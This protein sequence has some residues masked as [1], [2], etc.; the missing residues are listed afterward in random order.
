M[1]HGDRTPTY[2]PI[3][4][5]DPYKNYSYEPYGS[6][7]LTNKGK[8][9]QYEIGLNL[10][11]RYNEFL[12]EKFDPQSFEGIS[13]RMHR[14]QTSLQCLLAG[15]FPPKDKLIWK[16]DLLW[17]PLGYHSENSVLMSAHVCPDFKDLINKYKNTSYY[18]DILV[19]HSD[20]I[21]Y[22]NKNAGSE[23]TDAYGAYKLYCILK[24]QS[25]LGLELPKWTKSIFPEKLASLAVENYFQYCGTTEAKRIVTGYLLRKI[26]L[27]SKRKIC[28]KLNPPSRKLFLYSGHQLNVAC[29]LET[30]G[31]FKK[32]LPYYGS[33]IIVE[34]H[35]VNQTYGFK[36]YYKRKLEEK[37]ELL[38]IPTCGEFC[39]FSDFINIYSDMIPTQEY[40]NLPKY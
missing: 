36:V 16:K 27:D 38:N 23:I 2:K 28:G 5:T 15:L 40:C 9:R 3:Y 33:F 1:W 7:E 12:G 26:L 22:V 30:L 37:L 11:K 20:T 35:N 34:L 18:K 21:E 17:Q 4:S 39:P 8:L 19:Q 6:G 24:Q 32:H 10:R 25:D 29:F 13:T 14:T 31:L